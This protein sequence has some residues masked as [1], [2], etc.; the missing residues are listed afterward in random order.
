M[1]HLYFHCCRMAEKKVRRQWKH[2]EMV[3]AMYAVK[4]IEMTLPRVA[5]CFH[6][7]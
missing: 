5:T 4:T 6:V 2:E 1:A 3:A 7:P